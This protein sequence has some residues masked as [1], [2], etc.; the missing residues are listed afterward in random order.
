MKEMRLDK[1]ITKASQWVIW[2]Y[3][4]D[5]IKAH[6]INLANVIFWFLSWNKTKLILKASNKDLLGKIM[7]S[8]GDWYEEDLVE[9]K[10]KLVPRPKDREI[11]YLYPKFVKAVK[12]KAEEVK[13]VAVCSIK[14]LECI[15]K[16]LQPLLSLTELT[17]ISEVYTEVT[18]TATRNSTNGL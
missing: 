15:T 9:A 18:G 12:D 17:K 6:H 16:P 7:V 10:G 4:R 5:A 2:V 8:L 11:S 3:N 13:E 14:I 1:D